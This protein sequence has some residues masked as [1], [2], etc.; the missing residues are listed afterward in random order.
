MENMV[1]CFL[2]L[3]AVELKVIFGRSAQEFSLREG[4]CLLS[5]LLG[6]RFLQYENQSQIFISPKKL[7]IYALKK[8][9]FRSLWVFMKI[10]MQGFDVHVFCKF[11]VTRVHFRTPNGIYKQPQ[12]FM[13]EQK[14]VRT[15]LSDIQKSLKCW[16]LPLLPAVPIGGVSP[17]HSPFSAFVLL[18]VSQ[19]LPQLHT[20]S[21]P[22][23]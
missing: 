19:A 18:V 5:S 9:P 16:W 13:N 6:N 2:R 8:F 21:L 20:D 12:W 7:R 23:P 11:L 4:H 15:T 14:Q 1:F 10:I 17:S 3:C 22:Q